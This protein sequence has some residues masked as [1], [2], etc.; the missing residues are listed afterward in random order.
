MKNYEFALLCYTFKLSKIGGICHME[1]FLQYILRS[2][3]LPVFQEVQ[4]NMERSSGEE[5]DWEI[6]IFK[7]T[8]H[9]YF[10]KKAYN[11]DQT[12]ALETIISSLK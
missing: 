4:G 6:V 8:Y 11:S 7:K 5:M 12:K 9:F 2:K 1:L 10:Y 3:I